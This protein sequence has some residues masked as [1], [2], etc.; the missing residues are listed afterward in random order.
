MIYEEFLDLRPHHIC[1]GGESRFQSVEN[2]LRYLKALNL[3]ID[4]IAVHDAARPLVATPSTNSVR[5]VVPEKASKALNRNEIWLVQ[6]PQVFATNVLYEAY[7]QREERYFTDDASVVEQL[8]YS[9]HILEG[10]YK[11]IKITFPEDLAIAQ[12]YQA[13]DN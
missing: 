6:T 1:L 3:P 9:I 11:N 4:Y 12:L 5:Q 13:R 2:G 8:G 7:Q 10:D